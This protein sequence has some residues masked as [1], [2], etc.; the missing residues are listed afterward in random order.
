MFFAIDRFEEE[1]AVL[2]DDD[3][4]SHTVKRA[5]LPEGVRQGDVLR[6]EG[7]VYQTDEAETASRRERVRQLEQLL[8]GSRDKR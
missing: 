4:R 1:W 6:R 7:D 3:G 5:S 2:Q 8:R